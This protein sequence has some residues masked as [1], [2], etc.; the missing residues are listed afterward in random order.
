MIRKKQE[1]DEDRVQHDS[2]DDPEFYVPSRST[3]NGFLWRG[4]YLLQ[5]YAILWI[6]IA[7]LAT[8][9]GFGIGTPSAKAKEI[10]E[11]VTAASTKLQVQIDVLHDTVS[12]V[13]QDVSALVTLACLDAKIPA[14]YKTLAKLKCGAP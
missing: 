3:D 7:W 2:P 11:S 12:A 5:K 13:K 1:L 10:Q 4:A 9:L 8:S 6:P 14:A